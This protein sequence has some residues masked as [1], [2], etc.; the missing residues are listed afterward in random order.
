MTL[1]A[2]ILFVSLV[3]IVAA[4]GHIVVRRRF[5]SSF[6][7][8]EN[9]KSGVLLSIIGTVYA[10]TI[11]F[12]AVTVWQSRG[13]AE[14]NAAAEADTVGNLLRD[15]SFLDG[16]V[17][18]DLD[19]KLKQYAAAVINEE[20]QAMEN[21]A[22]SDHVRI[23]LKEI[24]TSFGT[25]N[26][27][28]PKEVNIHAAMLKNLD[29]LADQRRL[30]LLDS[31]DKVPRLMWAVL[32]AGGFITVFASYLLGPTHTR[33]HLLMAAAMSAMIALTLFLIYEMDGPFSGGLRVEPDAMRFVIKSL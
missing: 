23:L 9:A 11:A 12:V 18:G 31:R 17:R 22:S 3:C 4:T 8:D 15:A 21:G 26:P 2:G 10:V 6:R 1:I 25:I 5:N 16:D 14:A 30:R 7:E 24:H 32:I 20:W 33:T 19:Q 27:V 13:N 29:D 28:S